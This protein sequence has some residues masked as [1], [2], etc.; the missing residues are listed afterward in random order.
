MSIFALRDGKV[1]VEPA[2][3]TIPEFKIIYERDKTKD[4]TVAFNELCYVYHMADYKS[5]Y[6]NYSDLEKETKI[7]N[8][9]FKGGKWIPDVVV[10]EAIRKYRELQETPAMRLSLAAR[11]AV[12]KLIEHYNSVDLTIVNVKGDLINKER[13][14]SFSLGNVGKIVESLDKVDE[15]IKKEQLKESK[16]RGQA[17]IS[18]YE[19]N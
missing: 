19:R 9:Y 6:H 18:D 2:N 12:D 4:K 17:D 8:D 11:K 13:D 14:L 16:I 1:Q 7:L 3:L 5:I 15:K 10:N